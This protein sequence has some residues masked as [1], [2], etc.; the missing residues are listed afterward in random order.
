MILGFSKSDRE[1]LFGS[2]GG[3]KQKSIEPA[4]MDSGNFLASV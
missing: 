4:Y 2:F 1:G 3:F